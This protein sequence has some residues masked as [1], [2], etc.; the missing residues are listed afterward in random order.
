MKQKQITQ[1]FLV[2]IIEDLID[3][4]PIYKKRVYNGADPTCYSKGKINWRGLL[5]TTHDVTWGVEIE[6]RNVDNKYSSILL[7]NVYLSHER[8]Q[9]ILIT[10]KEWGHY[11]FEIIKKF[12]SENKLIP[13]YEECF[14]DPMGS[15]SDY[16]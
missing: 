9:N 12:N 16:E 15:L 11:W 8:K 6:I 13:R 10:R 5:I 3:R 14:E 1:P 7:A 4:V 2:S